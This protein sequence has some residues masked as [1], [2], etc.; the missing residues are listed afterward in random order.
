VNALK[1]ILRTMTKTNWSICG[2][3]VV[4][5]TAAYIGRDAVPAPGLPQP[6]FA[7]WNIFIQ[8][9]IAIISSLISA[10]LA[11]KPKAPEPVKAR[12]PVVEEGRKI[13]KVYGT[14]WVDDSMVLAFKP[15]GT[16]KIKSKG[17][18]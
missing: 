18:K 2:L 3:M 5:L 11:P 14:V 12:V 10:A 1:F 7:F 17:K 15:V 8:I 6:H 16:I 4:A 9:G 13:G